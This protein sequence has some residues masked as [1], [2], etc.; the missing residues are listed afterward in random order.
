MLIRLCV[1]NDSLS[2]QILKHTLPGY[3]VAESLP[4]I[5][6]FRGKTS[7]AG[8]SIVVPS[9]NVMSDGFL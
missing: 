3:G 7:G 4:V 5:V 2:R 9:R 6:Q 8:V 1:G